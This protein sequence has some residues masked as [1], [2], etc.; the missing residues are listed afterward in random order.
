M[1]VPKFLKRL[2]GDAVP[3]RLGDA[4]QHVSTW[5]VIRPKKTGRQKTWAR[6]LILPNFH[7]IETV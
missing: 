7:V 2:V 1:A 4:L 5:F 3:S 6:W